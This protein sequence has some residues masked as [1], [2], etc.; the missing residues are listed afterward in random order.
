MRKTGTKH[1]L[2]GLLT[3]LLFSVFAASILSVLLTGAGVYSRLTLRDQSAYD[4]RTC[5]QYLAAKTRQA[6]SADQ[7]SVGSF[8]SGDA[9][10]LREEI[11]GQPYLTRIYCHDGWL[12]ELF[13]AEE[14]PFAPED[15]EKILPAL[16]LELRDEG[17][18]LRLE[19][20]D[21]DGQVIALTLCPRGGEGGLS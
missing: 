14:D 15:G 19:L 12:R 10:L 5:V 2:D 6:G 20:T 7:V 3:L 4:R 9:L 16:G 18:L 13:A 1:H 8:G 17:E 21:S 11:D